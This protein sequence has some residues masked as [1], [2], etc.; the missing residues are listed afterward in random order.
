[1]ADLASLDVFPLSD[2]LPAISCVCL[3]QAICH[4]VNYAQT[5]RS[6]ERYPTASAMCWGLMSS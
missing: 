1:M 6:S 4:L 2:E 5:L 3:G